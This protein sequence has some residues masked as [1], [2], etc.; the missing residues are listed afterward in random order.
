MARVYSDRRR[1]FERIV[2]AQTGA[3][4]EAKLYDCGLSRRE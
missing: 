2:E 1:Q 3:E 4:A